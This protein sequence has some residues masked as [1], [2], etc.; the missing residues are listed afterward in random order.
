VLGE[1][2]V[3]TLGEVLGEVALGLVLGEALVET[4]VETLMGE[5]LGEVL[6][7]T[8]GEVLGIVLCLPLLDRHRQNISTPNRTRFS[9]HTQVST[10]LVGQ[11]E[12]NGSEA[13]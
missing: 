7:E 11:V 5:V 1:V 3:E 8:L 13:R 4:L 10:I 6:V 2:Q 9:H 12:N